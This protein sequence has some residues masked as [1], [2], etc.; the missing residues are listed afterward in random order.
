MK[1]LAAI[2]D[3][4]K[5]SLIDKVKMRCEYFVRTQ[6]WP[7]SK[8]LDYNGWLCNFD[9]LNER[10]VAAKILYSFLYYSDLM[11]DSMLESVV[12]NA[13][14]AIAKD[15]YTED[16]M[17]YKSDIYYSAIPGEDGS[18][19]GS[20]YNF[21][22][23]L[24]DVLEIPSERL[25]P[26][27]KLPD[28]LMEEGGK[29]ELNVL[30]CDDFIGSGTQ[31]IEALS[32]HTVKKLGAS[33]YDYAQQNGH[34]LY[35]AATIANKLGLG[36][37]HNSLPRLGLFAGSVL[38]AEYNLFNSS[39]ICWDNDA[40]LCSYATELI[41]GRSSELGIPDDKLRKS[42]RGYYNQGLFLS[43]AHGIPDAV[44][45]IFYT[46]EKN[47]TPLRGRKI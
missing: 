20:G 1:R 31:C 40:E 18:P 36:N 28:V 11:V 45:A 29:R 23:K 8:K 34:C 30:F 39:C 17:F 4:A 24:R 22:T 16:E 27:E 25:V 5:E 2:T 42:A 9:S 14:C 32:T 44:P 41:L 35:V 43:F 19:T 26:P 12:G 7:V 6:I 10:F 15:C 38:G 13:V 21:L 47:W 46:D 33:L 37:I 3:R